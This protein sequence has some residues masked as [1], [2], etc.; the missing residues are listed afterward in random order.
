[1]Y[2]LTFQQ[3]FRAGSLILCIFCSLAIFAGIPLFE[4]VGLLPSGLWKYGGMAPPLALGT[5]AVLAALFL[6]RPMSKEDLLLLPLPFTWNFFAIS[7]GLIIMAGRLTNRRSLALLAL[8]AI[9]VMI[10]Y[11][12]LLERADRRRTNTSSNR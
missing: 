5:A 3:K 11:Y 10:S 12:I 7:M 6:S 4:A 8:D 9:A 1:M 2:N